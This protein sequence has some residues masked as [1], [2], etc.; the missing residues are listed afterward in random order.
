MLG[1]LAV[2]KTYFTNKQFLS[3]LVASASLLAGSLVLN[4]YAALY[5]SERASNPVT[6]IILSNFG[7]YDLDGVFIYGPVIFWVL[8][9][10]MVLHKPNRIPF[11]LKSIALFVVIRSI[12]ISMTHI[13]PFPT[14]IPINYSLD[15]VGIFTSGGDLFFSAHTGLPFLMALLFWEVPYLRYTFVAI[16]IFFGIVVLLA[17]LHYTIDV[18]AAFFITY[19]I[20]HIAETIFKKDYVMFR[21]GLQE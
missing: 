12:F 19:S 3:S 2:H 16:S 4:F 8:V 14:G 18:F 7:P 11:V 1:T 5:A 15:I 6:D 20:F 21:E 13:A 10:L 9:G 17:H